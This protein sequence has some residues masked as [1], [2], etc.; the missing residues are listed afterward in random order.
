MILGLRRLALGYLVLGALMWW[1]ASAMEQ[2]AAPAMPRRCRCRGCDEMSCGLP[3]C[4]ECHADQ[5]PAEG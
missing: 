5:V 3:D 4:D 2:A 1:A